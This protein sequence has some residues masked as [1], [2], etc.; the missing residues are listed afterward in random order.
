MITQKQI[1][2]IK[3]HLENAK[4]PVFFFDNDPDGL[5]SFLILQRFLGRG[6]GVAIKSFPG[7][8]EGYFKRVEE[9][10]AD[11]I[12][13]LDKPLIDEDFI[14]LA[15]KANIPL[16]YIDHHNVSKPNIRYYYNPYYNDKTNEPV[17]YVCY[18]VT[19]RKEDMWIAL[20][21]CL[22]DGFLP[23]FIN[24]FKKNN[25]ELIDYKYRNAFDILYNTKLGRITQI[26]SFG[27]K[28]NTTNLVSMMKF[29]MKANNANDIL[30]ENS[31]TKT[32]L[33]RFSHI[34]EKYQKLLKKAESSINGD[35]IFLTYSGDLSISQYTANEIFYRHPDKVVVVSYSNGGKANVSLRWNKDIR[36]PTIN[37]IKDID[38]A[39]GGGHEHSTGAKIPADKF[40]V[41]KENLMKEIEKVKEK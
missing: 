34:N 23:E 41:F 28:D 8:N 22:T 17:S 10:R 2:E 5:C 25:S 13:V 38:G 4:N 36:T 9:F 14:K 35:I 1:E 24:D 20:I 15:E 27:M 12:F 32:F 30:E 33:Q 7:L 18:N 39:T 21:G 11:Y 31:K 6:R 26:I 19:K 37:A 3:E 29:L 16:I 40:E